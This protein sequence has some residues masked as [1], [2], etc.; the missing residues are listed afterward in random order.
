MSEFEA[1]LE[2]E[3]IATQEEADIEN[4]EAMQR[5]VLDIRDR[6]D[7]LLADAQEQFALF[8]EGLGEAPKGSIHYVSRLSDATT[9]LD[10]AS[11][12]IG[13]AAAML[14]L[15]WEELHP[16]EYSSEDEDEL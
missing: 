10:T 6:V 1:Q 7:G 11:T 13:Y 5:D 12:V 9:Y 14:R 16:K 2:A 15:A 4:L 3:G 8:V